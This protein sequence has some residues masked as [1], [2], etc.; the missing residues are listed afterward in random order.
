MRIA[1]FSDI[2]N[3]YLEWKP[4]KQEVDIVILAG[5]IHVE[6]HGVTWA[7][8]NF[9]V[10][11]I[12]VP[13]N[14]EH[15]GCE[16]SS[17]IE[18]MKLLAKGTNVHI[19][20]NDTIEIDDVLFIGTTLWTDFL[21]YG[22]DE[23]VNCCDSAEKYMRDFTQISVKEIAQI[24]KLKPSDTQ[25]YF[26]ESFAFIDQSLT[27]NKQGKRVVITHHAPSNQSISCEY[28]GNV[29]SASFASNLEEY[30]ESQNISLW[31]HGHTHYNAD[32]FIGRTRVLSNQR[33]YPKEKSN[34][35]FNENI[36]IEI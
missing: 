5:D 36:I 20:T 14:H 10:P 32:Y 3:E 31:L 2:H 11:V 4:K 7:I 18:K 33:G 15:Y 23:E 24:R 17:N 13:G 26:A 27:K 1:V 6:H 35:F 12:Y 30:I 29:L 25:T 28:Q 19:L 9:D 22:K 34:Q 16:I 21:L 8:N